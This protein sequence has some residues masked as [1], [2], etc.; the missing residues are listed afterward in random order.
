MNTPRT[1]SIALEAQH[2]FDSHKHELLKTFQKIVKHSEQL[3]RELTEA[4]EAQ[5]RAEESINELND[6]LRNAGW[7]QG[8]IDSCAETVRNL[9]LAADDANLSRIAAEEER[10]LLRRNNVDNC[11]Q[12]TALQEALLSAE[13]KLAEVEKGAERY[14]ALKMRVTSTDSRNFR[15]PIIEDYGNDNNLFQGSVA[16]HLDSAVDQAIAKES[17]HD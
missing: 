1:S 16:G 9:E 5:A 11:L 13:R 8:E 3:E 15:F 12:I 17:S 2:E 10:E 7:G 4:K 14:R 6:I